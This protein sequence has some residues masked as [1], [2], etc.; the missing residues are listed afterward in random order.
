[1]KP[2][3]G[4]PI[5]SKLKAVATDDLKSLPL[6]EVEKK[7]ESSPDGLTQ[8]E[9]QKRLIQYGPNEIEEKKSN[10]LLKFLS[11]FWGPNPVDDRSGSDPVG[12]GPALA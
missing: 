7:L 1:M 3:A 8:A 10:E 11:F 6:R 5:P 12:G 9:A 2:R 4:H